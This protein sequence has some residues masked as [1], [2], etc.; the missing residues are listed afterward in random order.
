MGLIQ[1]PEQIIENEESRATEFFGLE[2]YETPE[3][4]KGLNFPN[5]QGLNKQNKI[6]LPYITPS[7]LVKH[8]ARHITHFNV[9][10]QV[11]EDNTDEV[12]DFYE[13]ELRD[14][15]TSG[16]D[17]NSLID[18]FL[19]EEPSE[20]ENINELNTGELNK[21]VTETNYD[22]C[23]QAENFAN[24][25]PMYE[26]IPTVVF[27]YATALATYGIS[28]NFNQITETLATQPVEVAPELA[29]A[30][31]VAGGTV[32]SAASTYEAMENEALTDENLE[33]YSEEERRVAMLYNDKV[34]PS[35]DEF[36]EVAE[37]Y[38]IT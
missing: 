5:G 33:P 18:S 8:E 1:S 37:S 14:L 19:H 23:N 38:G 22:T 15:E 9:S 6:E 29:A 21:L 32:L 27:G 3:I 25:T 36:L 2:E 4:E 26:A 31:L 35:L 30:G 11:I 7:Q 10:E 12:R 28:E 13:S 16:F 17:L 24:N 20:P 34:A